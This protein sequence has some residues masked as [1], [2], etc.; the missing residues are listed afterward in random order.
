VKIKS[1]QVI[2]EAMR[3]RAW[4]NRDDID[5]DTAATAAPLQEWLLASEMQD[6]LRYPVKAAKFQNV[7]SLSLHF[8][9]TSKLFF[10]AL[11]GESTGYKRAPVTA[12]YEVTPQNISNDVRAD[13]SLQSFL[14]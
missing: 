1:I 7:Q 5:F 2:G 3:M 6:E 8:Q 14:K 10:L 13:D 4:T 9:N 12:V 11:L